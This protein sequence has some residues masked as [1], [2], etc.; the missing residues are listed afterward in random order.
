MEGSSR[1]SLLRTF[2][3]IAAACATGRL[4]GASETSKTSEAMQSPF[5]VA[6][7]NDEISQDFDR[8]CS[9]A[10][11]DFGM[12]W[13]EL[14][15]MWGKNVMELNAAE[16]DEAR[17]ILA[18]YSLRVTDIASPLFKTDWPGAPRSPYGVKGDMHGAAETTFKQ[19]DEILEAG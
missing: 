13:I 3:A 5:R 10:A 4:L 19:Q 6:V 9:V 18:R 11:R 17:K 8:A 12:N 7:I 1:R 15:S 14:R 16:I 2:G